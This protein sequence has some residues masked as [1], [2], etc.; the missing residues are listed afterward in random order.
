M[1]KDKK[2]K[3]KQE[4]ACSSAHGLSSSSK[5]HIPKYFR[6]LTTIPKLKKR[7]ISS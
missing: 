4:Y 6:H 5:D 2:K 3:K 7:N 1:G